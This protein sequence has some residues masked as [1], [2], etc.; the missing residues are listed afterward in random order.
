MDRP[1]NVL[2]L[3]TG[4]SARSIMAE[5]ILNKLGQG[6]FR[7]YSAGSQP[8]GQVQPAYH[9][10]SAGPGLRHLGRFVRSRG[11]NSPSP[12]RRA[13]FRFH[14]LRQRGG[15]N[16]SGVAGP[17]DDGALGR[18][19]SG[20]SQGLPGRDR[21]GVQGC[22]PD[23]ASAHRSFHGAADPE[24]RS[25]QPATTSSRT[26][27]AWMM[28][29]RRRKSRVDAV[30]AATRVL[31]MVGNGISAGRRRGLRDHGAKARRR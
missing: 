29:Q 5:A 27:A 31:R 13:R 7:A 11:M 8:N 1:F 17:A 15:R 25:A 6:K 23:A 19:R 18:S 20:R 30:A 9:P 4:N 12:A 24:P 22:L 14:R 21:A 26:S 3:C 2:F 28:R 16:L 10:A